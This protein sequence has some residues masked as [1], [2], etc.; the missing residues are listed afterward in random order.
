MSTPQAAPVAATEPRSRAGRAERGQTLVVVAVMIV[1][2]VAFLGLVIDGGNVYA[3]RRQL[4]NAADAAA[5]AGARE[6]ARSWGKDEGAARTKID[7]YAA[8]NGVEAPPS[9][10]F[11]GPHVTVTVSRHVATY[12]ARV[13]GIA[14]IPVAAQARAGVYKVEK[15]ACGFLPLTV[16]QDAVTTTGSITIW[17]RAGVAPSPNDLYDQEYG[18]LNLDGAY[19]QGQE[20]S[21]IELQCWVSCPPDYVCKQADR[22]PNPGLEEG[23]VVNG[24]PGWRDQ[25]VG[26]IEQ[27]WEGKVVL[28]PV[29]DYMCPPGYP[30]QTEPS[31]LPAPPCWD[32]SIGSGKVNYHIAYFVPFHIEEVVRNQRGDSY[33]YGHVEQNYIWNTD[34]LKNSTP[35]FSYVSVARLEPLSP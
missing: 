10:S 23:Q 32:S 11:D 13:I 31:I 16:P 15:P 2:L 1:V 29:Y 7:E 27:C 8:R 5:L 3:Q 26:I 9:A 21:D 22:H 12:F 6:W 35:G 4:Q 18:W 24:D 20:L 33:I 30:G 19:D 34:C 14:S 28:L 17:D 25:L